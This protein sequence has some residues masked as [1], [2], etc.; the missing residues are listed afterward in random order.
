MTLVQ[1]FPFAAIMLYLA[2]GVSCCVLK[3]RASKWLC[4]LLNAAVSVLMLFTLLYTPC[5]AA[6]ATFKRELKSVWA[7]AGV[8]VMQCGIAWLIAFAVYSVGSLFA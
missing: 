2:G 3:A 7:T 1:N 6:I 5:V 8:I 4:L